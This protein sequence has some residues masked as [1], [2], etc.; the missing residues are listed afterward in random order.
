VAFIPI[1]ERL[2]VPQRVVA[3]VQGES[4]LNDATALVVY[5]V[6]IGAVTSGRFSWLAAAWYLLWSS[7]A[8]V[9]LGIAAGVAVVAILK[10]LNDP[11]LDVLVSLLAG[12][13]AYIPAQH[14][15]V[16]GVLATVTSAFYAARFT[17]A[18]IEP[19]ARVLNRGM[20]PVLI[21]ILNTTI[22]I[23]LGLQLRTV[24][25][26]LHGT[27]WTTLAVW[28]LLVA[29][30]VV[31]IRIVWVMAVAY[32][33]DRFGRSFGD[34]PPWRNYALTSWAGFRG[35]VSLAAALAIP[36]SAAGGAPFPHRTLLIFL[37]FGVILVTLVGQGITLPLV[38][39]A[40]RI[41]E[42]DWEV[43]ERDAALTEATRFS[44]RR[45]DERAA[46]GTV[47]PD[48]ARAL[49]RRYERV[50]LDDDPGDRVRAFHRAELE[51][52]RDQHRALV[53]MRD[54][55]TIENTT[56]RH[57]ETHLDFKRLQLEEE[58]TRNDALDE[59]G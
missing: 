6:A 19:R 48:T 54:R 52:L 26:R 28:A 24:V 17:P 1:A 51:L 35:G 38:Q 49:R 56:L 25:T 31:A 22:F 45:L 47:G 29:G 41:E 12:Y 42:D 57:L 58:V 32:P 43:R 30:T 15:G 10:Q 7:A 20:W 50:Q 46:R 3:I 33:L 40:L 4:L 8:A 37:T 23:F 55:G 44:L 11:M 36:L 5:G 16:S 21:F 39:R 14:L 34:E 9:A 27:P 18:S 2:G 59:S 53:R 13:L